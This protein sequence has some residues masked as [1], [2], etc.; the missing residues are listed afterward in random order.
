MP[1]SPSPYATQ[2]R[3]GQRLR[4]KNSAYKWVTVIYSHFYPDSY[5]LHYVIY[6]GQHFAAEGCDLLGPPFWGPNPHDL[7]E[8]S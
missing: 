5:N 1:R 8:I 2:Y 4:W 7:G 6:D 3:A